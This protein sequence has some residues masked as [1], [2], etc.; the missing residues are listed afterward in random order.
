MD[1]DYYKVLGVARSASTE[2]IQ[3]AYR[4]LARKYH[5]DVNPDD[6]SAKEKFQ[7]VQSAFDVLND[8]Q[9]RD[10]YDRYGSAFESMGAGPGGGPREG[11]SGGGGAGPT[12][13]NVGGAEGFEGF[14]FTQFFSDRYQGEPSGGGFADL[15]SQFGRG[16]RRQRGPARGSDLL[17]TIEIPFQTAI[18]GGQ[19]QVSVARRSG[20]TETIAVKIPAG[21]EDGKKIRLRGQGESPPGGGPPG[22]LI[23]LIKVS[24]HP[25][26]RRRGRDLDVRVPVSLGEAALGAK[27]DLP[28]PRGTVTLTVPPGTSSGAKLRV[29]GFGVAPKN[30]PPGD[31]FAEI[32]I[33]LPK[34]LD[35]SSADLVR[36]LESRNPLKLRG[37]LRW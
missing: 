20:K 11:W 5:P 18:N 26:F 32:Q 24:G 2:D 34:Q 31:L 3:K 33:V 19:V 4:Q 8:P 21:V 15:F 22:A 30:G 17:H 36:Q 7:K 27:I 25:F 13:T 1:E 16:G 35:E 23:L 9:K 14:D 37:D 12:W 10:L 6:P 28:T 29:K